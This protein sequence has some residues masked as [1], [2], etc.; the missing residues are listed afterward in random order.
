MAASRFSP[1]ILAVWTLVLGSGGL[2]AQ[3]PHDKISR[4]VIRPAELKEDSQKPAAILAGE[5]L[6]I[7]GQLDRNPLTG[8]QPAGIAARARAAMDNVGRV[9][10][11]AGLDFSHVVS[12]HV[13]LTSMNDY[14]AMSDVYAT[15]FDPRRFPART[16]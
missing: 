7:A 11:A 9:L 14:A 16:T 3:Q 6:Y 10:R 15:Y 13:Y 4:K 1:P 2:V 12:C 5:T 8:E